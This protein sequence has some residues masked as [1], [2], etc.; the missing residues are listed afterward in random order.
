MECSWKAVVLLV[1]TSLGI[2]YTA[3]KSLRM[4]FKPPCREMG[5]ESRCLQK[6]FKDN[7]T[8]MFC[9][10]YLQQES[11][12]H[13]IILATTRS[14]SS[15]LGQI[16]NQNPDIFYLYEPLYHVQRAFTNSSGRV[17]KPID[18][19]SLLGA[20]RDLLHNLYNCDFYFLENYLRPIPKDHETSSFFRRGA[21]NALCLPPLCEQINPVNEHLCSKKCKTVNL[22]LVS[23]SCHRYKHM[24]IKTVRI[25]EIN[26]IRTLVEDPRLNL[27]VIHLVRDPRGILASR[28][29]TFTDLYRAWKI[30]NTLGRKPH[31]I[32]LSQI[33]TTCTD[34]SNSVE[35]GFSRPLWLKGKYMLVR[36]EDLARDP[37]TKAKEMYKFIGLEWKVKVQKWIEQNTKGYVGLTRNFK[38]STSRNAAETAENW[39]LH[40]GLGLVHALQQICNVTL[41]LLGYQTVDSTIQL[42]NLSNSL[43]EPKTFTPFT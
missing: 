5:S 38:F 1:F 34:L 19:R 2:Q 12:K 17:Q 23:D 8:R 35:T 42:R 9:E 43:V 7:A 25:P 31:N 32:D 22:T 26:D 41:S 18:R 37:V 11:R 3:I 10:D 28:M 15:F 6:E 4:A 36:Y 21:S 27:K 20:Y 30:W 13:I 40:L 29:N 33:T 16:F 24:A 14:G 39:R